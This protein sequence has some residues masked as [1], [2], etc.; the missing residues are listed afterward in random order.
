MEKEND[1]F[2]CTEEYP[3]FY[4]AVYIGR[5]KYAAGTAASPAEGALDTMHQL[6]AGLE[7]ALISYLKEIWNQD[8][9]EVRAVITQK[10]FDNIMRKLEIRKELRDTD[11]GKYIH[12]F[13]EKEREQITSRE[14]IDCFIQELSE[15]MDYSIQEAERYNPGWKTIDIRC[16]IMQ[17]VYE[18]YDGSILPVVGIISDRIGHPITIKSQEKMSMISEDIVSS[19]NIVYYGTYMMEKRQP[20]SFIDAHLE[21]KNK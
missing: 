18:A 12:H 20:Q 3:D 8:N 2:K 11:N 19:K 15:K 16:T 7:W 1:K 17:D 6:D 4:T 14:E 21:I 5:I 10:L 13:T 9:P